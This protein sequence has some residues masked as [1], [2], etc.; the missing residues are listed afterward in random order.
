VIIYLRIQ[1]YDINLQFNWQSNVL[2][3]RLNSATALEAALDA[4]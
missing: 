4:C 3:R 2:R 1:S